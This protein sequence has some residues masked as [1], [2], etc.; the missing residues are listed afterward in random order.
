MR[1]IMLFQLGVGTAVDRADVADAINAEARQRLSE[2][3]QRSQPTEKLRY[4]TLLLALHTLFGVNTAM[5]QT[6]LYRP[7]A[8]AASI[9]DFVWNALTNGGGGGGDG[10]AA[11]GTMV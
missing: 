5:I 3:V 7:S 4:S 2:L 6:L 1:M 9:D 8:P 10:D 11:A